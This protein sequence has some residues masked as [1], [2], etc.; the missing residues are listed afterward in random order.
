MKVKKV[1]VVESIHQISGR[2]IHVSVGLFMP[3]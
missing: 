2:R 3:K 1:G